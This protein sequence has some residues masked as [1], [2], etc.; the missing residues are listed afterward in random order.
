MFQKNAKHR[1][2][3]ASNDVHRPPLGRRPSSLLICKILKDN[4]FNFVSSQ[5]AAKVPRRRTAII[6][7][8]SY[9]IFVGHV[10]DDVRDKVMISGQ[11]LSTALFSRVDN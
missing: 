10:F 11:Q 5:A 4:T 8:V 6:G 3:D 9:H 1:A 2:N 7:K